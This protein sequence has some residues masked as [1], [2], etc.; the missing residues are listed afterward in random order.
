MGNSITPSTRQSMD[1]TLN[2]IFNSSYPELDLQDRVSD[3]ID[4]INPDELKDNNVMSGIDSYE[5]RFIVFKSC[6]TINNNHTNMFTTF[7]QRYNDNDILYHC[8]GKFSLLGLQPS[9]SGKSSVLGLQP[10]ASGKS[11]LLGLQPSASGTSYKDVLFNTEGGATLKQIEFLLELLNNKSITLN[12][13]QAYE[14][15]L[16]YNLNQFTDDEKKN[17]VI[18]ITLGKSRV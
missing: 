11:S 5:R 8:A 13:E 1:L 9:A 17:L 2:T 3:Y 10:S 6:I 18:N 16:N 15:K 7:F 4:F 14:F 12:Y